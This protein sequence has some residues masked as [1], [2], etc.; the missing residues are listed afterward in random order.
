M[1]ISIKREYLWSTTQDRYIIVRDVRRPLFG[2]VALAKGASAQQTDIANS[3]QSFYNTLSSDYNQQFANQNAILS[4]LQNSLNPIIQAGPDQFGFSKAETNN[5]NSQALQ[6]TGQQ[7]KSAAK[8][9]GEQQAAQGGGNSYLPTG[10]QAQQQ[11]NLAAN[12]A[13]QASSQLMGVQQAGYQQGY[14]QYQAAVGQLGAVASQYNPTGYASS[15]NSAGSSAASTANQVTQLNNAASPWNLVGGILGGAASAGLSA[16]TG[17]LGG[18]AA[19]GLGSMFSG[20]SPALSPGTVSDPGIA[21]YQANN[22]PEPG[23]TNWS[24]AGGSSTTPTL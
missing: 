1:D 3:Q 15:A 5:L 22:G 2:Q 11:A 18:T 16:F 10:A 6:G 23:Y 13:N 14:N 9:L 17:G 19:S 12:T 21:N 7:Y 8:S 20:G 4:T 24:G